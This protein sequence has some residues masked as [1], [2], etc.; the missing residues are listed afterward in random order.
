MPLKNLIS[1][2]LYPDKTLFSI[3][4]HKMLYAKNIIYID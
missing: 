4:F 2:I 3:F 1:S